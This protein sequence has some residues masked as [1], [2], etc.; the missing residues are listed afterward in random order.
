[1]DKTWTEEAVLV[2]PDALAG[3]L[4]G[5]SVAL[6]G[7]GGRALVGMPN[8][9]LGPFLG[10]AGSVRVFDRAGTTW[11][12]T[13]ALSAMTPILG[14]SWGSSIAMAADGTRAIAGAPTEPVPNV[15]SA[16][17]AAYVVRIE[18]GMAGS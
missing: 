2:P 1:N 12:H 5:F 16:A 9:A 6:S 14:A 11:T 13:G 3:E 18:A 4:A 17:G 10:G 7:D 15:A 8:D